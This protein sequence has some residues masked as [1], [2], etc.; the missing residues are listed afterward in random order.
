MK[1]GG[2]RERR[3]NSVLNLNDVGR[4]TD[5]QLARKETQRLLD[6]DT[7]WKNSELED[8]V[9][10]TKRIEEND[11]LRQFHE[12]LI[13]LDYHGAENIRRVWLSQSV[14]EF[15]FNPNKLSEER[16]EK[17]IKILNKRPW[18]LVESNRVKNNN[19]L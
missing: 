7:E 10:R 2:L 19:I 12:F 4:D 3:L 15:I 13:H 16:F 17:L 8:F 1:G 11:E 18:K 14:K 6:L 9:K 5:G